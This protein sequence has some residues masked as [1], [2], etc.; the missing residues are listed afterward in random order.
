VSPTGH[1]PVWQLDDNTWPIEKKTGMLF[2]ISGEGTQLAASL[3][4]QAA[5]LKATCLQVDL[6]GVGGKQD[7][8]DRA[9]TGLQF[10]SY[11][12]E[13]WDAFRDLVQD[14]EWIST[15]RVMVLWL[16]FG[17]L[18]VRHPDLA[19]LILASSV[20]DVGDGFGYNTRSIVQVFQLS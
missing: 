8:F 20:Q 1:M 9:A 13:N 4:R 5:D 19:R 6:S 14:F 16:G 12:G 7:L 11:F 15:E 2:R 17:D 10:P 18:Q 3:R